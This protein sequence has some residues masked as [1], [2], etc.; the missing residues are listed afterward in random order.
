MK[1]YKIGYAPGSY[2]MF[3]IGHL[4]L[5]RQAKE[6]CEYLIVGVCSD[7][8]I[9]AYKGR[10]P[11][12]PFEERIAIIEAVRYVDQAVKVDFGNTGKID[13]WNLYHY[14]CHCSG[15]DH[16]EHWMEER[17]LLKEK[18]TDF[19]FFSY[20]QGRNTTQLR[21]EIGDTYAG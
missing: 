20:T 7:E 18:G 13:A 14:D 4:N 16:K 15:D 9:E 1:Q 8:L 3:H 10:R 11:H 17:A 2:D 21:K 12:I 5:I 19:L 6:R